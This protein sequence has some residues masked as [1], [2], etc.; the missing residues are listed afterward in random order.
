MAGMLTENDG[1]GLSNSNLGVGWVGKWAQ[2]GVT[3]R[4][5]ALSPSVPP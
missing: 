5:F 2:C 4:A 1:A 3:L